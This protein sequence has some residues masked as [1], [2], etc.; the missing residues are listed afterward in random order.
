[1]TYGKR[2]IFFGQDEQD[3]KAELPRHGDFR[4]GRVNY[5]ACTYPVLL[6]SNTSAN[7]R[8]RTPIRASLFPLNDTTIGVLT[9]PETRDACGSISVA[10]PRYISRREREYRAP[11]RLLEIG[12]HRLPEPRPGLSYG[13]P[14]GLASFLIPKAL[15]GRAT[16]ALG[17]A[18]V[19]H[20]SQMIQALR[21]RNNTMPLKCSRTPRRRPERAHLWR[22]QAQKVAFFSS[23]LLA[24]ERIISGHFKPKNGSKFQ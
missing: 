24:T 9:P 15:K 17:N 20:S 14:S 8:V 4:P 2:T 22:F 23:Q 10:L 3:L 6:C 7:L 19:T 18:Q 13:A 16:A 21:E 1:M 11:S 12:V 5:A